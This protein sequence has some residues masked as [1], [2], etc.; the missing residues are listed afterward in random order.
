MTVRLGVAVMI[1]FERE[2]ELFVA[3][4]FRDEATFQQERDNLRR[5]D[6]LAQ[7]Q[8][9]IPQFDSVTFEAEK[10]I[11]YPKLVPAFDLL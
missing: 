1:Y 6:S 10:T 11:V 3:K 4:V 9:Y 2:G 8:K 7:L 5:F